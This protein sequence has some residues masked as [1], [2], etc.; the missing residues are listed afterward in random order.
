MNRLWS[1][2]AVALQAGLSHIHLVS[3]P[4]KAAHIHRRLTGR[5]MARA[6]R[7]RRLRT[8]NAELW[9]KRGPYL[10]KGD[11]VLDQLAAFYASE[12]RSFMKLAIS[13]IAWM[14]DERGAVYNLMAE[15]GVTGLEIVPGLF[16]H[17]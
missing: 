17:P 1:D 4:L 12:R 10:E 6:T 7:K 8:R 14:P 5:D 3:E 15:A 2:I 11:T 9:G 13:N 16:F